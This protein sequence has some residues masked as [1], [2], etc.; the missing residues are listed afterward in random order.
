MNMNRIS[1]FRGLQKYETWASGKTIEAL[2]SA[3]GVSG[4]RA[5]FE[6][7]RGIFA[8]VQGARHE[9]FFRLGQIAKRPWVMFPEWSLDECAADAARLDG[10][11]ASYLETLTDA[12]LDVEVHYKSNEGKPFTSLRRDILTH[13]YN[14]STYHRGQIAIL[15]KMAGGTPPDTTDFVVSTRRVG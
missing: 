4:D 9:W 5:A 8:H 7:A 12:D 15:V 1:H 14:H 2:R 10:L 13:V 6:R 3:A 11:W